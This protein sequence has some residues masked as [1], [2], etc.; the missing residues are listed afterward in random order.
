L[1]TCIE[2]ADQGESGGKKQK[3]QKGTE[4]RGRLVSGYFV[5]G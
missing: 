2:G 3:M 5:L 1:K 4:K